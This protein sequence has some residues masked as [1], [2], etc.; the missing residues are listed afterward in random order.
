MND[1]GVTSKIV[2]ASLCLRVRA[3]PAGFMAAIRLATDDAW[4]ATN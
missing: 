3:A 1:R 2:V 4:P